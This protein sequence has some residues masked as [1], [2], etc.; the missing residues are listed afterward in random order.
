MEKPYEL[1]G[2]NCS[3]KRW[4]YH[5]AQKNYTPPPP[6]VVAWEMIHLDLTVDNDLNLNTKSQ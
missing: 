2:T 5:N 3:S 6:T 1:F 4:L